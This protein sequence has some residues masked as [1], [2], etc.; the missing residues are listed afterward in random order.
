MEHGHTTEEE[1]LRPIA[2]AVGMNLQILDL[3]QQAFLEIRVGAG[4]PTYK[5]ILAGLPEQEGNPQ[6]ADRFKEAL[7]WEPVVTLP[8]FGLLLASRECSAALGWNMKYNPIADIRCQVATTIRRVGK[9][10]RQ[11]HRLK[12]H[13]RALEA[14]LAALVQQVAD[15][16]PK[17]KPYGLVRKQRRRIAK[18]ET[19]N[20]ALE[21][22][23]AA[24]QQQVADA[25]PKAKPKRKIAASAFALYTAAV[26]RKLSGDAVRVCSQGVLQRRPMMP[27]PL[28]YRR[29]RL[30]SRPQGVL[31]R[32]PPST[33]S[34]AK[35]WWICSWRLR[36]SS[37]P[38][39]GLTAARV[40]R[41]STRA[42]L[43][44]STSATRSCARARGR[45][46]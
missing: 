5:M 1:D 15:A 35:T 42:S 17:A 44:R 45:S 32:G 14:R 29:L 9:Q 27:W 46:T 2:N 40:R 8:P 33:R 18:L 24:L 30:S 10:R 26:R 6:P 13:H 16:V 39:G 36:P 20:R 3:H 19:D 22:R 11:I 12:T 37:R 25:V 4:L 21:A 41:G 43:V 28:F 34:P 7:H 23:L 31:R 38:P